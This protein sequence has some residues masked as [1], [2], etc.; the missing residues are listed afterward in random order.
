MTRSAR[1]LALL[2]GSGAVV[3]LALS[4]CS[5]STAGKGSAST[6]A[7]GSGSGGFPASS[8]APSTGGPSA[9][10]SGSIAPSGGIPSHA[11]LAGIVL[12]AGDLPSGWTAQPS[13]SNSSGDDQVQ[14]DV[15]AC[16]GVTN[17]NS[18]N[19]VEEVDSDEFQQ[20]D[21]SFDSDATS[22]KVQSEIE[23]RLAVLRSPKADACFTKALQTELSKSMPTGAKIGDASFHIDGQPTGYPSNVAAVATGTITVT[24]QQQTLTV[25]LYEAFIVG[26]LLGANVQYTGVT[27]PVDQSVWLAAVSAVARRAAAA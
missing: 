21:D 15:A 25:H 26:R 23:N 13:S 4:A 1:P 7:A 2:L 5:S 16:I 20:S 6:P 19:R 3:V 24:V 8:S 18:A 22:F 11:T 10:G 17:I 14:Q 12:R 9:S 27:G